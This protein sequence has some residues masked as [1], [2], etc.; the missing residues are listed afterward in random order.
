M[1]ITLGV[2]LVLVLTMASLTPAVRQPANGE[3]SAT[4][5][6][7]PDPIVRIE[8]S[9]AHAKARPAGCL[10]RGKDQPLLQ[11]EGPRFA[12]T[13]VCGHRNGSCPG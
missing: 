12:S 4:G 3:R 7:G 2:V 8:M 5:R 1:R 13:S 10:G 6:L 11:Y 9:P